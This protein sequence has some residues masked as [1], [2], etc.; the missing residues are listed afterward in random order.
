MKDLSYQLPVTSN[1]KEQE[2][3]G[4]IILVMAPIMTVLLILA[5]RM[6]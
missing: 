6:L 5:E 1:Q 4:K 2:E 3:I